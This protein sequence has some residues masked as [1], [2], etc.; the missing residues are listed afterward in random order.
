[1]GDHHIWTQTRQTNGILEALN[2]L[3]QAVIAHGTGYKRFSSICTVI[4]VCTGKL[5]FSKLDPHVA[6]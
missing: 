3:F 2:G 1:M 6:R 5:D 4:L